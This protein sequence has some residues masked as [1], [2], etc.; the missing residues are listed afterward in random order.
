MLEPAL[1]VGAFA[2]LLI[3]AVYPH[4]S[5][6]V[7]YCSC[8][9]LMQAPSPMD[10]SSRGH[11]CHL[12][13]LPRTFMFGNRQGKVSTTQA[14]HRGRVTGTWPASFCRCLRYKGCTCCSTQRWVHVIANE[15]ACGRRE[16]KQP[17][18]AAH[19][20]LAVGLVRQARLAAC[21]RAV[22]LVLRAPSQR[23]SPIA[24]Q[25]AASSQ[26]DTLSMQSPG[27]WSSNEVPVCT[28][29]ASAFQ[30]V[31]LATSECIVPGSARR[32]AGALTHHV[33]PHGHP[34]L[35]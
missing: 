15:A 16:R 23:L 28:H 13:S 14:N 24:A 17:T 29:Q 11:A 5:T 7:P 12:P 35:R 4:C 22:Q 6:T 21:R 30:L 26:P 32:A 34:Q 10:V 8:V 3:P 19:A 31:V 33:Y 1:L 20:I 27:R 25:H 18:I 2:L 9:W